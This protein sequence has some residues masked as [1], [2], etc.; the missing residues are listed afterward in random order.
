M[1]DTTSPN[2]AAGPPSTPST[3]DI[4]TRVL[5]TLE[6]ADARASEPTQEPTPTP[7]AAPTDGTPPPS[8]AKQLSDAEQLLR[9]QG[10]HTE[11]KP[12]GREHWIPRSKVLAM[13]ESG[14]KKRAEGFTKERA[15]IE[16]RLKAAQ[17]DAEAAQRFRQLMQQDPQGLLTYMAQLDPRY[18]AFLQQEPQARREQSQA[19]DPEPPP[20]IDLGNGRFTYSL[21]GIRKLRAWDARQTERKLEER[22]KPYAERVKAEE[23]RA[24]QARVDAVIAERSQSQI[25][26]AKSWPKW[27]EHEEAILQ[28]LRA[29]SEE[30][31]RTGQP[32]KLSLHDA[33][34]QVV[35]PHLVTDHGAIRESVMR[36]LNTAPRSTSVGATG[37]EPTRTP[38]VRTTQEIARRAMA[39][40]EGRGQ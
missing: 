9:E 23:S 29:D 24:A 4:A 33:Y 36:E 15:D 17:T 39:R 40:L 31:E 2:G 1:T 27:A 8:T 5:D 13:I 6:T 10:Y 3:T 28:A 35:M 22:L 18:Q 37:P 26:R 32:F 12:D 16:S 38:G 14:L 20:D 25:T 7:S 34:M 19:D 30:A 21:D 11:R